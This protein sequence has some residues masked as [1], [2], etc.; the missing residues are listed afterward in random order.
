MDII[1]QSLGFKAGE[2][3]ENFTREKLNNL[4]HDKIV[5]ANVTLHKGPESNPDSNYCEIRL[6]VPGN[7]PFVK[8]NSV[9][10]ETAISDCVDVL[11][12]KLNRSKS[13]QSDRLKGEAITIQNAIEAA[14]T[15]MDPELEDVVK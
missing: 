12:E 8:K 4:N 13:K 6:E 5:R 11:K 7:D 1:I 10:F 15:D 2:N 9:H 3:L 14:E